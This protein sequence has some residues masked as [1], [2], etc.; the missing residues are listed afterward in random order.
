MGKEGTVRNTVDGRNPAPP[1]KPGNN[2]PPINTNKQWLPMVS[3]WCRILSIHC[4]DQQLRAELP[5][6]VGSFNFRTTGSF[7][8]RVPEF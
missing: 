4:I 7:F 6:G 2:D 1:E 8:G 5:E 3:I